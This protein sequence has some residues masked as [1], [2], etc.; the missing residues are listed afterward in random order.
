MKRSLSVAA[1]LWV[2]VGATSFASP[3]PRGDFGP[4]TKNAA[5]GDEIAITLLNEG[6]EPISMSDVWE[7]RSLDDDGSAQ[8][9]WSEE[10]TVIEGGSTV[11]WYWD[12]Y[13]NRCY[14]IC[15]NVREGDPAP[16]GR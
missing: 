6:S 1:I 13:V 15:Q 4:S 10:D 14:G 12:Q 16:V 9:F 11:T 7:I 3:V 2:L 5:V 8:Y